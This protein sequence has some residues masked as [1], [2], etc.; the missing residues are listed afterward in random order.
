MI[1]KKVG[2]SQEVR[3]YLIPNIDNIGNYKYQIWYNKSE[4]K[5]I[6]SILKIEA[7]YIHRFYPIWAFEK[8]IKEAARGNMDKICIIQPLVMEIINT[9]FEKL[10]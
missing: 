5:I 1:A 7:K 2:F 6:L 3:V 9:I 10:I 4:Y 8:C